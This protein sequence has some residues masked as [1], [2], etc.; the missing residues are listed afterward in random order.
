LAWYR[1]LSSRD[2]KPFFP[3]RG[4]SPL[5]PVIRSE[6]VSYC[7]FTCDGLTARFSD[8]A[9]PPPF[10]SIILF[11]PLGR[12]GGAEPSFLFHFFSLRNKTV[13]PPC[14]RK[15]P[16]PPPPPPP[17]P[18]PRPP[19]PFKLRTLENTSP[20]FHARQVWLSPPILPHVNTT[21]VLLGPFR[22][23]PTKTLSPYAYTTI[24]K[25]VMHFA[26]NWVPSVICIGLP[27][28]FLLKTFSEN[29]PSLRRKA[30]VVTADGRF[31]FYPGCS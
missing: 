15:P 29:V 17:R 4:A 6:N 8:L 25:V 14:S 9:P 18:S 7:I 30:T 16:P 12:F 19:P 21:R 1:S 20:L 23:V 2:P 26:Q 11:F 28:P 22:I 27:P 13:P 31:F 24:V 10:P 5:S 3:R